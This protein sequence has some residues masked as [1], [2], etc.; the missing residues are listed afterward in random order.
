MLKFTRILS[1]DALKKTEFIITAIKCAA[2]THCNSPYVIF[3]KRTEKS[4]LIEK[5]IF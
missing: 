1:K 2:H 5:N 4:N 3:L